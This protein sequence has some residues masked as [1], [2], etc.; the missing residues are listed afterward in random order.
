[1]LEI[2]RE[3]VHDEWCMKGHIGYVLEGELQLE[4]ADR[5]VQYSPGDAFF[6]EAGE[7]MKRKPKALSDRVL[8]FIG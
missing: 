1:M 6:L 4:Y 2:D 3:F 8:M 7:G 5:T